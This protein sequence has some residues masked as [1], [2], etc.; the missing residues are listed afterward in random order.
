M[1]HPTE[2]TE[3]REAPDEA[4]GPARDALMHAMASAEQAVSQLTAPPLD[5]TVAEREGAYGVHLFYSQ[6]PDRITE[7]AEVMDVRVE[8]VP[9]TF[10]SGGTFTQATAV[11]SGIEVRAWTLMPAEAAEVA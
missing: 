11:I 3:Q 1:E 4:R 9:N 2:H 8:S 10:T 7:F 5:I 6:R